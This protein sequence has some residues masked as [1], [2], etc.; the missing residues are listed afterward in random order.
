MRAMLRA[1]SSGIRTTELVETSCAVDR[2]ATRK[3]VINYN[4]Y[5]T[6]RYLIQAYLY[7]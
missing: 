5:Y 6:R 1:A 7:L 4:Q 3:A 2:A